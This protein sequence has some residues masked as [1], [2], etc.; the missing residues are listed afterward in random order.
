MTGGAAA[1]IEARQADCPIITVVEAFDPDDVVQTGCDA[2]ATTLEV[3]GA[4]DTI[5]VD[6]TIENRNT[7]DVDIVGQLLFGGGPTRT[8]SGALENRVDATIP[9]NSS[10]TFNFQIAEHHVL[11]GAGQYDIAFDI[12]EKIEASAPAVAA[13]APVR[14]RGCG[15]GHAAPASPLRAAVGAW[16]N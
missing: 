3:G 4:T 8:P 10:R 7:V 6:V 13:A 9:A 1:P 2:S 12:E 15:C 11:R 14:G 5:Q 16:K